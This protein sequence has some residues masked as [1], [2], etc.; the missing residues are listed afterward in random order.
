MT[1]SKEQKDKVIEDL[2]YPHGIS[3]LVCDGYQITL[4]VECFKGM[5]YRVMTY[6]NGKYK[7]L[8]CDPK[9]ECPESIFMRKQV[10]KLCSPSHKK[11]MEKVMGK[12]YIA[13]D[14]FFSKTFTWYLPDFASGKTAISHLCKVSKSIQV[15]DEYAEMSN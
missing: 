5:R 4:S 8:W 1:L 7:G 12:R 2:S 13:K 11:E 3:K 9:N 14:P 10:T 15:M 6:I